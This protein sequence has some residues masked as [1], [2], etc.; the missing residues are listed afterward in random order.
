MLQL[1]KDWQ[2]ELATTGA[3]DSGLLDSAVE[4]LRDLTECPACH[5]G[6]TIHKNCVMR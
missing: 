6:G 1:A 4:V 5:R 2:H 3:A